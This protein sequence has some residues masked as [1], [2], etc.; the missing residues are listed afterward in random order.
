[1]GSSI[2]II[3][4]AFWLSS[5]P[6]NDDNSAQLAVHVATLSEARSGEGRGRGSKAAGRRASPECRA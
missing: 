3:I 2:R 5:F 6:T 1:M 4:R